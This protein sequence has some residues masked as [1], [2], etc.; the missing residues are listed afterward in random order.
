MKERAPLGREDIPD[1]LKKF[2]YE[3]RDTSTHFINKI[4]NAVFPL[5]DTL[6][7]KVIKASKWFT[8]IFNCDASVCSMMNMLDAI[9]E[10]YKDCR[11]VGLYD[12]LERLKFYV[13]YLDDFEL[14]DE[15]YIKMNSR[16]LDL[17]PFEN[18]KASL[19]RFM[20]KSGGSFTQDVDLDGIIM[21]YY[22]R[23]STRMDTTWNDIFWS[24]P[25]VPVDATGNVNGTVP[26]NNLEK[27]AKFFRFIIRYL[28]TKLVLEY[29]EDSDG[30]KELENFLYKKP[31][32]EEDPKT[33]ESDYAIKV[34]LVGWDYFQKLLDKL[35]FD[36]ISKLEKVL[37]VM[38]KHGAIINSLINKNPYADPSMSSKSWSFYGE[39]GEFILPYRVIFA[40]VTEFIEHIPDGVDFMDQTIQ[41]NLS[42]LLRVMWNVLAN[43]KTEDLKPTISVIKA[44]SEL[45]NFP[46]AVNRDF[47]W[48]ISHNTVRSRN[49][50]L[51][52][53]INKALKISEN[54]HLDPEWEN[55]FT[56]AEKH[57]LFK[58]MVR[59][60]YE[61][62]I[63]T[64]KAFDDRYHIMEGLFDKD[65]ITIQYRINHV[66]LR[67]MIAKMNFW[68]GNDGLKG[69]Y[70]TENVESQGYLKILLG[71]DGAKRLFC[72]LF[73]SGQNPLPYF[74]DVISNARWGDPKDI[75]KSRVFKRLVNDG[76]KTAA[77]FDKMTLFENNRK[78]CF[79]IVPNAATIMACI[80]YNERIVLNTERHLIFKD[81]TS[82]DGFAFKGQTQGSELASPFEDVWGDNITLQKSLKDS[83]GK[84]VFLSLEFDL[85]KH[86]SFF[87]TSQDSDISPIEKLLEREAGR[88][89]VNTKVDYDSHTDYQS[90]KSEVD[91]IENLISSL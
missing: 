54:L 31:T 22:L 76:T 29:G 56:I 8:A 57:P 50:Q 27:D 63:P 34:R 43:T 19:I 53:E 2:T 12:K 83:K 80:P 7:S 81:L 72:D 14:N 11:T 45:I 46:G 68:D 38:K 41:S 49:A 84:E 78:K 74:N 47:Y 66:L 51:D 15:L 37:E 55:S 67:A 65:G 59:F 75:G 26:I 48:S 62:S 88:W 25:Q 77:L 5:S 82:N 85:L 42:K 9:D 6:P 18:F 24:L 91:R 28:F 40:T 33:A 10:K 60:F 35:G 23:F 4:T 1:F 64:S 30:Y 32:K 86:V 52:E 13:L 89:K 3:T 87:I 70:I 90:I 39:Y 73:I 16:G 61:E 79:H 58:G 21:P 71:T 44:M 20:K 69:K 17:T 36:G